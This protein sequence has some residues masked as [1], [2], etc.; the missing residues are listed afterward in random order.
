MEY[1]VRLQAD[2][3]FFPRAVVNRG[4]GSMDYP[5]SVQAL[6]ILESST[7]PVPVVRLNIVW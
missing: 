1:M 3:V 7:L 5:A 2:S 6:H 4:K